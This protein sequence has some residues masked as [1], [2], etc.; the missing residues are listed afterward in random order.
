ME[1][2]R[3]ILGLDVSTSTIGI[4]VVLDDGSKYGKLVELTHVTPKAPK[5]T[6]GI[7]SLFIKKQI[8]QDEFLSKWKDCGI[9]D[10]VIEEPLLQSNNIFTCATLMRFNSMIADA[11]YNTLHII[12][13]FISSYHARLYAFPELYNVRKYKRDG[14]PYD[15]K[16]ILQALS[17]SQMALFG[18]YPW[19]IDKKQILQ[20]KVADIFPQIDWLY[21]KKGELKKENYDSVDAY[22]CVLGLL[23]KEKHPSESDNIEM[24]VSNIQ[25]TEKGIQY[26]V[27]YWD[28]SET[29][30]IFL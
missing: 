19:D 7:E 10:V 9:T 23:N 25:Q 4:S 17:K 24:K 28:E 1:T 5:T 15:V 13:K 22:V 20:Q 21:N 12:P 11:V 3:I 8:F 26:T 27:S 2:N 18:A 30:T 16:K 14:T 6:K 29:K